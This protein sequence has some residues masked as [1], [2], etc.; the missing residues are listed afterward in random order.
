MSC[1][2]YELVEVG[3]V[4]PWLGDCLG[5]GQQVVSNC[6]LHNLFCFLFLFSISVLLSLLSIP[7]LS[8]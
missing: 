8:Y 1:S 3:W 2:M 5:I 4:T 6:I 7:F